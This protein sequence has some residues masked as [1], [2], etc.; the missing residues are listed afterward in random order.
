MCPPPHRRVGRTHVLFTLVVIDEEYY[1]EV[2][3]QQN[4]QSLRLSR[5]HQ[6]PLQ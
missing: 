2:I 6:H 1:K 5:D 3:L 4:P